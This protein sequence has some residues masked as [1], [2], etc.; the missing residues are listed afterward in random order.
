M[1]HLKFFFTAFLVLWLA[2]PIPA[3]VQSQRL[4]KASQDD[5]TRRGF[6]YNCGF[7]YAVNIPRGFVGRGDPDG[8]PQHGVEISLSEQPESYVWVDASYNAAGWRTLEDAAKSY[9]NALNDRAKDISIVERQI[10]RLGRLRALRLTLSY[11]EGSA[12][13][14]VIEEMILARRRSKGEAEIIYKIGLKTPQ[15]TYS[16][17][18]RM[19]ENLLRTWQLKPLPCA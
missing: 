1:T 15:T 2:F 19:L 3:E 11:R 4:L 5:G 13:N 10:T 18:R 8:Q 9:R 7:G 12:E 17:S 14:R 6:Y 16:R